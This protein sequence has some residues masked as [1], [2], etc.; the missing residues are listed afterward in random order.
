[1]T[2]RGPCYATS[3]K[4]THSSAATE[5][6]DD[7]DR[8]KKTK[9]RNTGE[10]P[11]SAQGR[12][13][14]RQSPQIHVIACLTVEIVYDDVDQTAIQKSMDVRTFHVAQVLAQGPDRPVVAACSGHER[15]VFWLGWMEVFMRSLR[16]LFAT[17]GPIDGG[18]Q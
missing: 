8:T 7:A 16:L 6:N 17:R 10:L 14:R 5:I 12:L 9:H 11:S 18:R 3:H 2:R 1:M 4:N 13:Q 15:T